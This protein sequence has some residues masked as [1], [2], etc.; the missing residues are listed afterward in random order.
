MAGPVAPTAALA[1]ISLAAYAIPMSDGPFA[2]T[3]VAY[4]P[5]RRWDVTDLR[6]DR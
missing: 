5:G 1:R 4:G 6:G 2:V 3:C